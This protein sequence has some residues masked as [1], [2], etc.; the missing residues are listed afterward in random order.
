M[1]LNIGNQKFNDQKMYS[2]K[3]IAVE[4]N[5]F[6]K[7]NKKYIKSYKLCDII[8]VNVAKICWQQSPKKE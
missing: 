2:V 8:N 4:I 7:K 1:K 5:N 6:L 3:N